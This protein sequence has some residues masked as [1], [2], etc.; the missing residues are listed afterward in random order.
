MARVAPLEHEKAGPRSREL[1]DEQVASHGRATNMK[2]TLAHSPTALDALMR[3]YDLHAEV[4]S[5]LGQRSATLFAF[6]ISCQTECLICS[7]FFRRW[8]I[9]GGENPDDLRLDGQEKAL[10]EYG[11]QLARDANAVDDDVFAAAT[12]GLTA[13]QTVALTAF[14]ALMIATNVFNNALQVDLDEYLFPFRRKPI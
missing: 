8:L 14:G 9:E 2:R 6:A 5:F 10:V 3:W 1:L 13:A 11:R 4:V 7:T 12:R